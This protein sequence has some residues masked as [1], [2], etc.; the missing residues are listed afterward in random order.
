MPCGASSRSR[1]SS[2]SSAWY[3][4]ASHRAGNTQA[5]HRTMPGRPNNGRRAGIQRVRKRSQSHNGRRT[6][7]GL[8]TLRS[9][10]GLFSLARRLAS[11]STG[12]L[13]SLRI[14]SAAC[15][16]PSISTTSTWLGAWSPS[17]WTTSRHTSSTLR[18]PSMRD[19]ICHA[20]GA[21][22]WLFAVT[23]SCTTYQG[24]P[25]KRWRATTTSCRSRH[26]TPAT[27]CHASSKNDSDSILLHRFRP[28][29]VG[30]RHQG[31][32]LNHASCSHCHERRVHAPSIVV[33]PV[34]IL[35]TPSMPGR[36]ARP[37]ST[38]RASTRK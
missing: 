14:R 15:R 31:V 2:V 22:R 36:S 32:H 12:V 21:S 30:W 24:R 11:C 9:Q 17:S 25:R 13:R 20:A 27:R 18:R 5:S 29:Q 1:R 26:L 37:V 28:R 16:R 33:V 4:K 35:P 23:G 38:G 3:C 8:I 6:A 19:T 34:S 10:I 7:S